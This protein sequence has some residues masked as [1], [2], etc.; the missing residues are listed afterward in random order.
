MFP[1]LN[2]NS[3][4]IIAEIGVNHNG[5]LNI[6][7]KLIDVAKRAGADAVKFQ[8]F[9]SAKLASKT[10]KKAA[11]QQVNDPKNESQY[12]ML[13]RLEL[14][15]TDLLN[16][17]DYTRARGL[18]F[19]S[20]PF[21]KE[22]AVILDQLNVAAFKVS[23]GDLTALG[24]LAHLAKFNRPMIISTGMGTLLETAEAVKTIQDNGNPPLA[25]LHCVSQYPALPKDVNL[26]AMDTMKAA[27]QVPIGWSDHT[28]G[29]TVS[30][31]AVARGARILE[32]HFTL[33][34]NM[35]GP[36]HK[37]SL[38]PD[39]LIAYIADIR[40]TEAALGDGIKRP[41][42]SE[43]DTIAAARRSLIIARDIE[44]GEVLTNENIIIQRP[45]TGLPPKTLRHV[46]GRTTGK[47]LRAGD[48]LCLEDL[49]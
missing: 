9:N 18:E 46:I 6:A 45:G 37:A 10:S 43:M 7:K 31:A 21:D 12:K 14:A 29:S 28:L 35:P 32:K 5:D 40:N 41:C 2:N 24:F 19:L 47:F 23:S 22:S 3:T 33:S 15:E 48:V 30:I 25:I 38:E 49:V 13:K 44:A 11:Y 4:Y 27:F 1:L 17:A 34:K 8:T 20:T 39:E 42:I 36:D 26:R 16:A